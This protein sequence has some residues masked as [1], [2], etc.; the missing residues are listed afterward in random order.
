MYTTSANRQVCTQVG[1][2]CKLHS[3]AFFFLHMIIYQK[4]FFP[5]LSP[6]TQWLIPSLDLSLCLNT[7]WVRHLS[8]LF[9]KTVYYCHHLNSLIFFFFALY[10]FIILIAFL[11]SAC[12]I[13]YFVLQNCSILSVSKMWKDKGMGRRSSFHLSVHPPETSSSQSLTRMKRVGVIE[14][15]LG[16]PCVWYGSAYLSN[17]FVTFQDVS[18]KL[19]W[20]QSKQNAKEPWHMA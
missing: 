4:H 12:F 13:I 8:I 14:L 11:C 17:D 5:V 9:F 6:Y 2:Y 3:I 20:K 16:F 10:F 18:R 19:N 7:T 1:P 15:L